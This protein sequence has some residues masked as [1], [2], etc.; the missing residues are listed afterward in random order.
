MKQIILTI[1]LF[2]IPLSSC[3]A[4]ADGVFKGTIYNKEYNVYLT[5]DFYANNVKVPGQDVFGEM[6][7][8]FGDYT[9]SRKWFITSAECVD[10]HFAELNLTNDY[11]SED[12]HA[13][14]TFNADSTF[15]FRQIS[16]SSLKIARN[17]KW[18][19]LPKQMIFVRRDK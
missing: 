14:L 5:I 17:R 4:Q 1:A 18:V 2:L 9:D 12:F 11:G 6:A 10:N 8:F 19:K 3:M 16:G 15:S 7:G 13:T